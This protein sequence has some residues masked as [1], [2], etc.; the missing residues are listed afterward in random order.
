MKNF[1]RLLDSVMHL[2][3]RIATLPSEIEIID[4]EL[5]SPDN[6]DLI[7]LINEGVDSAR[8][9]ND[10]ECVTAPAVR[11]AVPAQPEN[12]EAEI[13]VDFT[14]GG[15]KR[16]REKVEDSFTFEHPQWEAEDDTSSTSKTTGDVFAEQDDNDWLTDRD[17]EE[18]NRRAIRAEELRKQEEERQKHE[19]SSVKKRRNLFAN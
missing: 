15:K 14:S 8:T 4:T 18:T 1:A 9:N 3:V 2:K 11:Q 7:A 19:K 17:N 10:P 12:K 6:I 13:L 16:E 5:A